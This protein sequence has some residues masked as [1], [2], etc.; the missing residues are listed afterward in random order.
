MNFSLLVFFLYFFRFDVFSFPILLFFVSNRV[1]TRLVQCYLSPNVYWFCSGFFSFVRVIF[2]LWFYS[3]HR[4]FW[5]IF[6]I[7]ICFTVFFFQTFLRQF[8]N[9]NSK[10]SSFVSRT[11]LWSTFSFGLFFNV[12][13]WWFDSGS[14]VP[15]F[16]K[17]HSPDC[18]L[19]LSV[20]LS[21]SILDQITFALNMEYS[22][23]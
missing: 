18:T 21:I 9:P 19:S 2:L 8:V 4:S 16:F 3:S 7:F 13:K 11:Q 1:I 15:T 17:K 23:E 10:I 20:C 22:F 12:V 5:L 6:R 14:I